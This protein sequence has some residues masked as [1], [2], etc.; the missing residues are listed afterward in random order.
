[1]REEG[2]TDQELDPMRPCRKA[3][4]RTTDA[5]RVNTRI[6][7]VVAILCLC[8]GHPGPPAA[9][10]EAF[11]YDE[12]IGWLHGPCLAISNA[13]LT[14]GT[15]VAVVIMGDPQTVERAQIQGQTT[16][17]EICSALIPGRAKLNAK[18]GISFYALGPG[19][20]ANTDMG[21]GIVAPPANPTVVN[22]LVRVDLDRDGGSE[23]FFSCTTSEGI[24]FSIWTD[25]AYQGEPRWSGYYY[26]GYD[27]TPNCP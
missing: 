25:K 10:I 4:F 5:P 3:P 22:G 20:I 13:K 16:S 14:P 11:S 23:V 7:A 24:K 15:P 8:V 6:L 26:L 12:Q 18:P 27:V 17:S 19:N 9:A 1:M 21:I 2:R